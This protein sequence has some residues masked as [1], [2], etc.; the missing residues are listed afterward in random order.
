MSPI[1]IPRRKFIRG[2]IATAAFGATSQLWVG[3][4]EQ[5]P[6]STATTGAP[7]MILVIVKLILRVKQRSQNYPMLN[8]SVKQVLRKLL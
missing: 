2:A 5:K 7:K 8:Y 3:C 4:T 1:Y 6:T